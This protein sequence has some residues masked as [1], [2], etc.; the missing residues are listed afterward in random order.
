M[1]VAKDEEDIRPLVGS[2]SQIRQWPEQ[3]HHKD[4]DQQSIVGAAAF[5]NRHNGEPGEPGLVR[6]GIADQRL[7]DRRPRVDEQAGQHP[8]NEAERGQ[9]I[10]GGE[11][12]AVGILGVGRCRRARTA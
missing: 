5:R 3:Q 9:E 2:R 12:I 1:I 6:H 8:G 10:H 7:G 4:E 11:R